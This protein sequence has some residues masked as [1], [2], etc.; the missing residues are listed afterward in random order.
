MIAIIKL[1]NVAKI[2]RD[3]RAILSCNECVRQWK[4]SAKPILLIVLVRS[5]EEL[6]NTIQEYYNSKIRYVLYSS[7]V[8][9]RNG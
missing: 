2:N 4:K 5:R 3:L 9:Q 1:L 8:S 7:R 6:E